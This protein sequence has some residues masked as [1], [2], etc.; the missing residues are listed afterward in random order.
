MDDADQL[1]DL[2]YKGLKNEDVLPLG[3]RPGDL[4]PGVSTVLA[5]DDIVTATEEGNYGEAAL[6]AAGFLPGGKIVTALAKK[7]PAGVKKKLAGLIDTVEAAALA[8]N[9]FTKTQAIESHLSNAAFDKFDLSKS[10]SNLGSYAGKAIYTGTDERTADIYTNLLKDIDDSTPIY[11]Y[12]VN[13]PDELDETALLL[14]SPFKAQPELA[15]EFIY[16][17]SKDKKLKVMRDL[18]LGFNLE[19]DPKKRRALEQE[20]K[21]L[22][23][24]DLDEIKKSLAD[25]LLYKTDES[26][27][28]QSG[29][30]AAFTHE[31]ELGSKLL[32]PAGI[33]NVK[34]RDSVTGS[35]DTATNERAVFDDS[36]IEL[37]YR[38]RVR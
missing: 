10:G 19:S 20:Y 33:N 2:I 13:V 27:Y 35:M 34:L 9:P 28:V 18:Q 25:S 5:A 24:T 6:G 15:K 22:G 11:K 38:Y 26:P 17:M 14:A 32:M 16:Q 8:S 1:L 21:S 36:L 7:L 12:G 30:L 29:V 23:F 37:I 3:I 31:P 4:I